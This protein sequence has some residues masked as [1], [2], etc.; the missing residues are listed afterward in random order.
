MKIKNETDSLNEAI[1]LL[2]GK[3]AKELEL[4]KELFNSG[5][6]SLKP[7]N[8]IKST[9]KEVSSSPEIKN[10]IFGYAIGITAGFLS[11]K[12]WVGSSHSPVKRVFGTILQFA[13]ANVVSK[14]SDRIKSTG[15]N[16]LQRFLKNRRESKIELQH[17]GNAK[18]PFSG[19]G[20]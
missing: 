11:R 18:L 16:L 3:R 2:E 7:I 10:N 6:E 1:I 13:I 15:D 8:L 20:F 12:L 19:N 9:F 17:N 5:Y 14:H 4:L